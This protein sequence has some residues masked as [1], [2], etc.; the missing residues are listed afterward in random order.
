MIP[1]NIA[2]NTELMKNQKY[3]SVMDPHRQFDAL[4]TPDGHSVFFSIGHD[5]VFY[6]TQELPTSPTGWLQVNL[7][8]ILS[9]QI[10]KIFTVSD[11][12]VAQNPLSADHVDLALVVRVA[13]SDQLFMALDQ[14]NDVEAWQSGVN[15][16]YVPYDCAE[17]NP[18][19]PFRIADTYLMNTPGIGSACF[20]D[21][22]QPGS[23]PPNLIDRFYINM[24]VEPHWWFRPLPDAISAGSVMS[25]VGKRTNDSVG[26]IYTLGFVGTEQKLIYSPAPSPE[27]PS[28]P[29]AQLY[30]P[31][32]VSGITS[33]PD[34]AGN[35]NLFAVHPGTGAILIYTPDNQNNNSEPQFAAQNDFIF[36]SA[37][38]WGTTHLEGATTQ[39]RT[40]LWGLNG[41]GKV[42]SLWCPAGE[43]TSPSAWRDPVPI[44][45]NVSEFATYLNLQASNRVLF[46]QTS[47][48]QLMQLTQD[49][50][51][52]IWAQRSILLPPDS[53]T[54]MT[55]YQSYTTHLQ[56]IDENSKGVPNCTVLVTASSPVSVYVNDIY[57]VLGP[58]SPVET[59]T[60]LTGDVTVI[61][62]T[63]TLSGVCFNVAVQPSSGPPISV[64]VDPH[65]MA[66][67]RLAALRTGEDLYQAE[68]TN[69]DGTTKP[70]VPRTV[71]SDQR[72][73]VVAS[74]KELLEIKAKLPSDGSRQRKP[75]PMPQGSTHGHLMTGKR[76]PST[77]GSWNE[78]KLLWGDLVRWLKEAW[79]TVE[80]ITFAFVDNAWHFFV[81]AK[82][83]LYSAIIDSIPAVAGVVE[84]IFQWIQVRYDEAVK[85]LGF[86]F[87]WNDILRTHNVIKNFLRLAADRAVTEI[88]QVEQYVKK[89]FEGLEEKISEWGSIP[90][91]GATVGQ[92]EQVQEADF[93][94]TSP[95]ANW[96]SYHASSNLMNADTPYSPPDKWSKDLEQ[97][98]SDLS[99]L[100][101]NEETDIR[102]MVKKVQD[103]IIE[104][105]S[106]LT[107]TQIVEKLAAIVGNFLLHTAENGIVALLVVL[108]LLARE[109][110][111]LL[112]A[113]LNIPILTP[114]YQSITG[115]SPFT[116]LDMACLLSAI[117]V[118]VIY[119]L[120]ANTTAFPDDELTQQLITA[121]TWD[122][123]INVIQSGP[124]PEQQLAAWKKLMPKQTD[125]RLRPSPSG[126][127]IANRFAIVANLTSA[128]AST[129]YILTSIVKSEYPPNT[130]IPGSIRFINVVTYLGYIM[131]DI[132]GS[133]WTPTWENNTN[134]SITAVS[135][136]KTLVD[137]A[138]PLNSVSGWTQTASPLLE[139]VI[140]GVWL[141]P[142]IFE[143]VKDHSKPEDYVEAAGNICFDLGGMVS[144]FMSLPDPTTKS[145]AQ[146]AYV[147]LNGA[148]VTCCIGTAVI[149][150]NVY[151]LRHGKKRGWALIRWPQEDE[152]LGAKVMYLHNSNDWDVKTPFIEDHNTRILY[153]H[154]RNLH[155]GLPSSLGSYSR[156]PTVPL[157]YL[158][159][160]SCV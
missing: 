70:L 144:P 41:V 33:V 66:W 145:Y 121:P 43:E 25:F 44:G 98:L 9:K 130:E 49:P 76:K 90:S 156:M 30:I 87:D 46:L 14:P 128:G 31:P 77:E 34:A 112:D 47:D 78:V 155:E 32:G 60:T 16:L 122:S 55:E 83:Y 7:S 5:G 3:A 153:A 101:Q 125:G 120:M 18:V 1:Q 115:G 20:V 152:P 6:I 36:E 141:A 158:D 22:I 134:W 110:L 54:D 74:F 127:D 132:V 19:V 29:D 84:Y 108:K 147:G 50:E 79:N 136:L 133:S 111:D 12:A 157:N 113:P 28:P 149:L 106:T 107:V 117:P 97:A 118:T 71:S 94:H 27:N 58:G 99:T 102:A 11:F 103:S 2:Y 57:H 139:I 91:D 123:L 140:N 10:N 135:F 81:E 138:P 143:L 61:Q 17:R 73:S 105:Y 137:N 51:T 160:K 72:D 89:T 100:L 116:F 92:H 151:V 56:V 68:I 80:N 159:V 63:Q 26:G 48:D 104:S 146:A 15:W 109:V 131:P 23:S 38:L 86:V 45:Y 69:P 75:L 4:Q 88:D 129:L 85:Y 52:S 62:E 148:Y 67:N 95:Q 82:G 24:N 37:I 21:V 35:T 53:I 142:T 65:D 119:K 150:Q 124:T 93:G 96:A 154:P 42:F 114:T 59:T 8:G 40:A 13:D 39:D 64:D 126:E